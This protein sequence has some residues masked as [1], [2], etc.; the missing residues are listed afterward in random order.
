MCVSAAGLMISDFSRLMTSILTS[1][2][3]SKESFNSFSFAY[4]MVVV[5]NEMAKWFSKPHHIELLLLLHNGLKIWK[6]IN[7]T[8][9][10]FWPNS[11]F[12]NFKNG[13][14][15]IFELGKKFKT[16]KNAISRKK[17][18]IYLISR[19]FLPGLF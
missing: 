17:N 16:A 2:R 10:F 8:N 19:V 4:M 13:Q 11:S 9:Y 18:L 5:V 7:F 15:S 1:R 6:K 12:C 3:I 14:K